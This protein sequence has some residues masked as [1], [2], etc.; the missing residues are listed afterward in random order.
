MFLA[1][2]DIRLF[3]RYQRESE[4]TLAAELA[5]DFKFGAA[6]IQ[7]T[8]LLYHLRR[9]FA[10]ITWLYRILESDLVKSGIQRKMTRNIVLYKYGAALS[11]DLALNYTRDNRIARKMS[12]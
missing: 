1:D 10:H 11:H 8:S 12:S 6:E 2:Y 5:S 7:R 4:F 3:L 9:D